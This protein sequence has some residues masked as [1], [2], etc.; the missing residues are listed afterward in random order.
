MA[1]TQINITENGTKTLATAGKYCDRNIDINVDVMSLDS[2]VKEFSQMNDKVRE[3][4]AAADAAYTDSNSASVSVIES[5]QTATGDKDR[6]LGFPLTA[7]SGN[8]YLQNE[9]NGNGW[10]LSVGTDTIR[11]SVFNAI[12][13]D[14]SQYLVKDANGNL[15]ENGRI[16][17]TGKVRMIHFDGYIRNCRDLGGWAC[18]GGTVNYGKLFRSAVVDYSTTDTDSEIGKILGIRRHIDL[19]S[20]ANN[21]TESCLGETVKYTNEPI[22]LYY[23]DTINTQKE[24]YETVKN[25]F[26]TIFDAVVHDEPTIYHCSLGRDRTGTITF[27]I[28]GLLGVSIADIDKDFELSSFSNFDPST[29]Y[30][31]LRTRGDYQAMKTY[32]ATFGGSTLRD[33]IVWWF[34]KAGFSL[35]ELNAFRAAMTDGTPEELTADNFIATYTIKNKLTGCATSNSATSAED[36][37][38]YS[39]TITFVGK[40]NSFKSV[41]VTMGGTDVTANVYADG[42]INIASVTGDVVITAVAEVVTDYTNLIPASINEDGTQYVGTNGE[43]GYKIGYRLN[44][45]GTETAQ[46][47]MKVTGYM[48]IGDDAESIAGKVIRFKNISSRETTSNTRIVFYT[49]DFV[50]NNTFISGQDVIDLLTA[51]EYT[52]ASLYADCKYFRISANSISDDSI[53]TVNEP[54]D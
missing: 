54:I 34:I 7:T 37:T 27:M 41:K 31:A 20:E 51:G 43:D 32:L 13:G 50:K 46:G 52:V 45:S 16:K 53:V 42:V 49:S 9:E 38:S 26:R 40:Y 33:N 8:L 18:D 28:L 35:A 5:Y 25:V 30:P 24:D 14:V 22:T 15:L 17:P 48:K 44:S 3:Y 23:A 2:S 1:N 4:L 12:P 36:G 11:N 19:R 6:P 47:N 21:V 10:I 39:A 29:L